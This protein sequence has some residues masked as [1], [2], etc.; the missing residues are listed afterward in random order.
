MG[1]Q[2]G[3]SSY[4]WKVTSTLPNNKKFSQVCEV[5]REHK[6]LVRR[7]QLAISFSSFV[8]SHFCR[9]ENNPHIKNMDF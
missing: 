2:L 7:G 3:K 6:L 1:L 4:G 9:T 5:R 8:K